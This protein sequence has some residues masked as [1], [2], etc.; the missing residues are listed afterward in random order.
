[1][2]KDEDEDEDY[3]DGLED[4]EIM[5]FAW[6]KQISFSFTYDSTLLILWLAKDTSNCI[7]RLVKNIPNKFIQEK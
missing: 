7:F 2:M 4:T 5:I 6:I 1:M 3:E